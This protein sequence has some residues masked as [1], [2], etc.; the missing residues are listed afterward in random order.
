MCCCSVTNKE[1]TNKNTA[2]RKGTSEVKEG[3]NYVDTTSEMV[4]AK[5]KGTVRTLR[6]LQLLKSYV[7]GA[8]NFKDKQPM[9]EE[10]QPRVG[11]E[12]DTK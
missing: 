11:T 4:V 3:R 9:A 10:K 7:E 5:S 12:T 6:D 1:C 2:C 8:G